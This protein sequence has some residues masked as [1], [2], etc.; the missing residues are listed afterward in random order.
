MKTTA[1]R[2]SSRQ[3]VD[4]NGRPSQ[5]REAAESSKTRRTEDTAA[6]LRA[7]RAGSRFAQEK[8]LKTPRGRGLSC[9][10]M[11]SRSYMIFGFRRERAPPQRRARMCSPGHDKKE[12][13]NRH[14]TV[15][16]YR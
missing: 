1:V 2:K 8:Q 13:L 14:G 7:P 10:G 4:R 16:V 12:Q 5:R 9:R 6:K 11:E 15:A 3:Q